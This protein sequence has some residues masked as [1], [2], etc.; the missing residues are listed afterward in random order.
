MATTPPL[1]FEHKPGF[2]IPTKH[3]E[4]I[5]QLHWFAKVPICQL[6]TRYKL[7][8]STIRRILSYDGPE[9]AHPGQVGP[10][11]TIPQEWINEL[12]FK[13]EHWV[14]VLME[15]HGWSTPN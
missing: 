1:D 2:E 9:R 10:A 15:R 5:R 13:Q 8:N 12:I 11:Q 3:K 4:A 7:G 6:K 14:Y